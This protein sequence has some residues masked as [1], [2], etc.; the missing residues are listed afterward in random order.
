MIDERG[1]RS[2]EREKEEGRALMMSE[3]FEIFGGGREED[4]EGV[5]RPRVLAG[6]PEEADSRD[7]MLAR[8]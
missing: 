1:E 6:Q 3:R 2:L 5:G 7:L 4:R 8:R